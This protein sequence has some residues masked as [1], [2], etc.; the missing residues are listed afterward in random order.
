ML[1]RPDQ[2]TELE[3]YARKR[4][5]DRLIAHLRAMYPDR[6]RDMS[7]DELRVFCQEGIERGRKLN[8]RAEYDVA[9]FLEYR[10]FLGESF[11]LRPSPDWLA[12]ILR[13]EGSGTYKMDRLDEC[14]RVRGG[15]R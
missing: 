9:R 11:D 4:F 7:D 10:V 12:A 1:I 14:Y 8:I 6:L 5:E 15:G 3:K 2:H 13:S